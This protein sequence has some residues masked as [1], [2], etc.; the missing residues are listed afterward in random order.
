M[1]GKEHIPLPQDT[2][3]FICEG[4]GAVSLDAN[5]ICKVQGKG[6]KSDWCGVK[7]SKPPKLCSTKEHTDRWQCQ[8]CGQTAVNPILLCDPEKLDIS[9]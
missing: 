1:A 2:K 3:A 9:E 8:N 7:G 4:C 5:N 6:K